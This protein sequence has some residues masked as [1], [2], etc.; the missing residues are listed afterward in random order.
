MLRA[1]QT[2]HNFVC[3]V[4][5]EGG[6]EGGG[7]VIFNQAGEKAMVFYPLRKKHLI[8]VVHKMQNLPPLWIFPPFFL[9]LCCWETT[10]FFFFLLRKLNEIK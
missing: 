5:G 6:V 9:P 1:E 2:V 10:F 4:F 3:F 7:W 8:K